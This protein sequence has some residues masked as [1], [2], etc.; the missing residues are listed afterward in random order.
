MS[1]PFT[2]NTGSGNWQEKAEELR[3]AI[4]ER[5]FVVFDTYKK[6]VFQSEE[7][8]WVD[9]DGTSGDVLGG[10][11]NLQSESF[12]RELMFYIEDLVYAWVPLDEFGDMIDCSATGA[13]PYSAWDIFSD[14]WKSFCFRVGGILWNS[15][16]DY[17]WP[18]ATPDTAKDVDGNFIYERGDHV[19]NDYIGPWLVDSI[20]L[21]LQNLTAFSASSSFVYVASSDNP[22]IEERVLATRRLVTSKTESDYNVLLQNLIQT[23]KVVGSDTNSSINA[24][25]GLIECSEYTVTPPVDPPYTEWKVEKPF[26]SV[27]T[28][29]AAE[30]KLH[31]DSVVV[32]FFDVA[33]FYLRRS[34]SSSSDLFGYA[35]NPGE[36]RRVATEKVSGDLTA[37]YGAAFAGLNVPV[38]SAGSNGPFADNYSFRVASK[39]NFTNA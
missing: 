19:E 39:F 24:T 25:L 32:S 14:P 23:Y 3:L 9:G 28:T 21:A 6:F 34:P 7:W 26:G 30:G 38:L 17:G 33:D 20:V 37:V 22:Q 16:D 8:Q 10:G 12:W 27:W 35:Y 15:E 1:T 29:N 4:S 31:V 18:R 13:F 5:Y 2:I 36:A 11:A